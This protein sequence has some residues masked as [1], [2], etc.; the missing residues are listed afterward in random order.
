MS[1]QV[2]F[3]P[4]RTATL[5]RRPLASS[6][7][8]AHDVLT[9]GGLTLLGESAR[10][11]HPCGHGRSR[12]NAP[13]H[14]TPLRCSRSLHPLPSPSHIKLYARR[15]HS[16]H[17]REAIFCESLTTGNQRARVRVF[18][19]SPQIPTRAALHG[20][21][22][23]A[24]DW[25]SRRRTRGTDCSA[26]NISSRGESEGVDSSGRRGSHR[27]RVRVAAGSAGGSR[28]SDGASRP[29]SAPVPPPVV[30]SPAAAAAAA[31]A[32]GRGQHAAGADRDDG[33]ATPGRGAAAALNQAETA[34][35]PPPH[36]GSTTGAGRE[37]AGANARAESR[38]CIA[39]EAAEAGPEMRAEAEGGSSARFRETL[40]M[41]ETAMLAATSG[42]AFFL[43]NSL[44]VEGYL[45]FFFPLPAVVAS[46]RWGATAGLRT[47][48]S[49]AFLLLVLA[50]PIK[51]ITF[52]LLHGFLGSTLGLCWGLGLSWP[53]SILACTFVRAAGAV[54]FVLL[55]SWLIR[56]NILKLIL[57]NVQASLSHVFAG[58]SASLVPS[59][60]LITV[61]FTTLV[62]AP[63]T[64]SPR[65][66][67]P[68][69]TTAWSSLSRFVGIICLVDALALSFPFPACF[70]WSRTIFASAEKPQQQQ[71]SQQQSQDD[72]QMVQHEATPMAAERRGQRELTS[73]AVA[74]IGAF[75]DLF[76]PFFPANRSLTQLLDS[77]DRMFDDALLPPMPRFPSLF[78]A[79]SS[80]G[81]SSAAARPAVAVRTPW[82]VRETDDAFHIRLDMPGLS[83]EEVSVKLE[84][85]SL[86][87]RG[88][89]KVEE[90]G[91]EEGEGL[92]D[93]RIAKSYQT[94]LALPDNVLTDQIKA[95]M[96]N[97]VLTVTMAKETPPE[98]A[99]SA[100][101]IPVA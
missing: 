72:K 5:T 12:E 52:L 21:H 60:S 4:C 77:V 84:N 3:S 35:E 58:I 74:P 54:S 47:A 41:V 38:D 70:G 16:S 65:H 33:S 23:A 30:P 55:S 86:V 49:A 39:D 40:Q 2:F 15:S 76:D 81:A 18:T 48:I 24:A 9:R 25:S 13:L 11:V 19:Q 98:A 51:A 7:S 69:Q 80:L 95:E 32:A 97:G 34:S 59:F 93:A 26:G 28:G 96:K 42:L 1:A 17:S 57:M 43:A 44:R 73:R 79:T 27:W 101:E 20:R 85:G 50:G 94:T 64:P 8:T 99:P 46:M 89:H 45:G 90:K 91:G 31:A 78:R 53:I 92:W 61:I 87:I 67:V 6:P 68:Q 29:L 71:Q 14:P 63:L 83:K 56:E 36:G 66:Q 75:S 62:R 82:D 37:G 88:E 100:I 10:G 22:I